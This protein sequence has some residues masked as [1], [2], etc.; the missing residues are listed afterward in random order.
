MAK[1]RLERLRG[2]IESE[3]RDEI[4]QWSSKLSENKMKNYLIK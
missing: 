2:E 3:L 4:A 1:M